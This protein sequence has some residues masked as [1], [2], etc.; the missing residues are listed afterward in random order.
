[1]S[2]TEA[3]GSADGRGITRLA[4]IGNCAVMSMKFL[5]YRRSIDGSALLV[6]RD[7]SERYVS[8]VW[9]RSNSNS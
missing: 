8:S 1:M 3:V 2:G 9:R 6:K 4:G 5:L 7:A